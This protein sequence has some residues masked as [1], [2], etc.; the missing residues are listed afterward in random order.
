[1]FDLDGGALLGLCFVNQV[2]ERHPGTPTV[3][4]PRTD[5]MLACRP[6]QRLYAPAADT[7]GPDPMRVVVTIWFPVCAVS[8]D[9]A[10]RCVYVIAISLDDVSIAELPQ[11]GC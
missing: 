6:S 7:S 3:D 9:E 4:S 5:V 2:D 8:V 11:A 1:M 10:A